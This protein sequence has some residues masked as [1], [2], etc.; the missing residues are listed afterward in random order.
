[1][2]VSAGVHT[3]VASVAETDEYLA[4]SANYTFTVTKNDVKA[5][6]DAKNVKLMTKSLNF[7][8]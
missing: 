7:S 1:M 3:V 8:L 2:D 4:S 6:V 5:A